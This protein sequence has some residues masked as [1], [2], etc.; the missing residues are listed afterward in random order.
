MAHD[1]GESIGETSEQACD[2]DGARALMVVAGYPGGEGFPEL[3]L[4]TTPNTKRDGLVIANI[5]KQ[6]LGLA[7]NVQTV[8]VSVQIER[9]TAIDVE[10][11]LGG[12]GGD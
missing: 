12:A 10:R 9:F 5:L 8:E 11:R 7:V 3:E 4:M 2:P 1:N 6:E